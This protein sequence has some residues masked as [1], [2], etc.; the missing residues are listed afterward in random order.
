MSRTSLWRWVLALWALST[1]CAIWLRPVT[2]IDETRYLTVAWEMRLAGDPWLPMLNGAPYSDKPPL[3]FWLINSGWSMFGVSDVWPRLLTAAFGLGVLWLTARCATLLCA[4]R[5][6]VAAIAALVLMATPLWLLFNGAVM[7]D[8]PLTFFVL[9]AAVG[10]LNMHG[11]GRCSQWIW[12]GLMLGLGMLTKGPTVLL[13]TL[14]LAL[15]AP[16]WK[17]S[18]EQQRTSIFGTRALGTGVPRTSTR[19]W[20]WYRGVALALLVSVLVLAVWLG[21]AIAKGGHEFLDQLI[22]QQTIDRMATTTHHLRPVWFYVALLPALLFPWWLM[23]TGWRRTRGYGIESHASS[24]QVL[25]RVIASWTLPVLVAFSLFRG[26]Q[27]HYVFPLLPA[28]AVLIAAFLGDAPAWARTN[29]LRGGV[30]VAFAVLA[31]GY[32]YI[33]WRMAGA[34]D[35]RPMSNVI[36]HLQR[37]RVPIAHIGRYHGQFQFAGRLR[38]PLPIV[39]TREEWQAFVAANPESYL[40]AYF[41]EKAPDDALFTQKFRSGWVSLLRVECGLAPNSALGALSIIDVDRNDSLTLERVA[42]WITARNGPRQTGICVM[43]GS[44]R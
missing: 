43:K 9:A 29:S 2:P 11:E 25:L 38:Q 1:L 8:V 24:R 19:W 28:W 23:P 5:R 20:L 42:R 26:K 6:N 14:P 40:I 7:F 31:A 35:V 17:N 27:L 4:E 16:V 39:R 36:A 3:L 44:R 15:L 18:L 10:I 34:Y 33:G 37:S 21:P 32:G 12:V 41:K 13:H 30:A 22:W